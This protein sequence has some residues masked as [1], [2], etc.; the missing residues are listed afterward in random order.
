VAGSRAPFTWPGGQP[1]SLRA[2]LAKKLSLAA[3]V[4]AQIGVVSDQYRALVRGADV[5]FPAIQ[6]QAFFPGGGEH[7]ALPA[8]LGS[9]SSWVLTGDNTL[10]PAP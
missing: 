10:T 9:A 8:D 3:N 4:G 6:L 2:S 7:P 1:L 5:T